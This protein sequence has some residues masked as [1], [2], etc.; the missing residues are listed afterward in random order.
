MEFTFCLPQYG[1]GMQD[2]TILRWLKAEGD[3][4]S[5]GEELVEIEAAKAEVVVEAP[6][7]GTL[8]RILAAE[9]EVVLVGGALAVFEADA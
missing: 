5:E 2:A 1:M 4:V 9:D 3:R 6:V 8:A 7:T